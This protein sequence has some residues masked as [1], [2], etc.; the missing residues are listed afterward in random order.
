[1]LIIISNVLF[2][3]EKFWCHRLRS[4][5]PLGKSPSGLS[6][7]TSRHF[8][9]LKQDIW[10]DNKHFGI[11]MLNRFHLLLSVFKS[12]NQKEDNTLYKKPSYTVHII[13]YGPYDIAYW[14]PTFEISISIAIKIITA[15]CWLIVFNSDAKCLLI[16]INMLTQIT[17]LKSNAIWRWI[18][19]IFLYESFL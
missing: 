8:L 7:L 1:M 5:T 3:V 15:F 10:N 16:G 12:T 18:D 4:A 11:D 14:K 19:I 2:Q 6:H 13:W 17:L 9:N